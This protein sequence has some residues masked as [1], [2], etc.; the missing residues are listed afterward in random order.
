MKKIIIILS[1]I[2]CIGI[3]KAQ[4]ITF[5][6]P[7]MVCQLCVHG[8]KKGFKAYV[9]NPDTDI[10]VDLKKKTVSLINH[11]PITDKEIKKIVKDSGYNVEKIVRKKSK[12]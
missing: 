2:L 11:I 7:G 3:V 8:I 6:V 12:S 4:N 10:K 5:Q 9:R 1:V